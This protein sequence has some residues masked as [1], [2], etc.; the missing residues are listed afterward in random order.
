MLATAKYDWAQAIRDWIGRRLD[1]GSDLEEEYVDFFRHA[2]EGACYH[3]RSWFGVQTSGPS[4]VIGHAFLAAL[5]TSR[6]KGVWLL[7]DDEAPRVRG[8]QYRP[9]EATQATPQPLYWILA[10]PFTEVT[11]IN[12]MPDVWSSYARASELI[13]VSSISNDRDGYQVAHGKR[14]LADFW[15]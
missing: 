2:F 7:V 4:L 11:K 8:F 14:R 12:A 13:A 3:N 1:T 15:P 6:S 10:W 9:V 5:C